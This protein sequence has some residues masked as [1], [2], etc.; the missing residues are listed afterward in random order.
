MPGK[1]LNKYRI[2]SKRLKGWDYG[3]PGKYFI[4]I[5]T[6]NRRRYFGDEK[7]L[8]E[9]GHIARMEW[10]KTVE[11][12]QDMN[13]SL[14]AFVVMPDHIHGIIII[15]QNKCKIAMHRDSIIIYPE[16]PLNNC[17]FAQFLERN[18]ILKT[19]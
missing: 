6:H 1:F 10:Y 13:I 14:D 18:I 4:T 16:Y 5:C 8:S 11:I 7:Q 3:S 19:R 12:R 17:T 9:L 2:G 15:G